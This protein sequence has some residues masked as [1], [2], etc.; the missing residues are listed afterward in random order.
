MN[1]EQLKQAIGDIRMPDEKKDEV[2]QNIVKQAGRQKASR[3]KKAAAAAAIVFLLLLPASVY[4]AGGFSWIWEPGEEKNEIL[5][6]RFGTES[7]SVEAGGFRFCVEKAWYDDQMGI[8][9]FYL[10]VTDV[11]GKGRNPAGYQKFA[12]DPDR[13]ENICFTLWTGGG[14]SSMRSSYDEPHSTEQ[15][16]YFYIELEASDDEAVRNINRIFIDIE[17]I[18]QEEDLDL[19]GKQ[20]EHKM[21][22]LSNIS[23]M[24]VL[25]WRLEA[26]EA[27]G[28]TR[29]AQVKVSP[30]LARIQDIAE[31]DFVIVCRDGSQID[32]RRFLSSGSATEEELFEQT[33][34]YEYVDLDQVSGIR[35]NGQF[36]PVESAEREP[37][38]ENGQES[39]KDAGHK[40][41]SNAEKEPGGDAIQQPHGDEKGGGTDE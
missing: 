19:Q 39:P 1:E 35:I 40:T 9:F 11:S 12:L 18:E 14:S 37:D 24:P 3:R 26:Q 4:A 31:P 10:S 29:L 5:D 17:Q 33:Y 32:D 7:A 30:I 15:T 8:A 36:Y 41:Q 21:I 13:E 27:N 38:G 16:A 20:I 28:R 34:R 22:R 6:S 2:W 25:T 23:Q